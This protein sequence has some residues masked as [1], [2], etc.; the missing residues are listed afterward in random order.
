VDATQPEVER[1]DCSFCKKWFHWDWMRENP[2]ERGKPV[3][4]KNLVPRPASFPPDCEHCPKRF[5]WTPE[6]RARASRWRAWRL[7]LLEPRDDAD[8][9]AFFRLEEEA[10]KI[11]RRRLD[12][13]LG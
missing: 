10:A 4:G 1:L 7:R 5:A 9:W 3:C 8:R 12:N 6:N 11:E 13:M 2:A